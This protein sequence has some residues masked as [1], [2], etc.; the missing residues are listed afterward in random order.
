VLNKID[1]LTA[2]S[3]SKRYFLTAKCGSKRGFFILLVVVV[4]VVVVVVGLVVVTFSMGF[5]FFKPL[6]AVLTGTEMCVTLHNSVEV[7]NFSQLGHFK[8]DFDV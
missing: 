3:G 2:K 6:K 4:V 5:E 7:L 1:F 8:S